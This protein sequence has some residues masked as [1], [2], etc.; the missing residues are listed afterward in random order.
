MLAR[1]PADVSKR[2]LVLTCA[3]ALVSVACS[4]LPSVNVQYGSGITFI[5]Y[6]ADNLDDAGL[7]NAIALDQD[8]VPYASYLIFPA[9][10]QE[11]E[12]AVPRPMP[13]PKPKP[14]PHEP[15]PTDPFPSEPEPSPPIPPIPPE[16]KQVIEEQK[17]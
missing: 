15:P 3:A 7:G 11:G 13:H 10:L 2:L 17:S 9:V 16:L 14:D 8:G 4:N 1:I 12:I 5:P 6:V